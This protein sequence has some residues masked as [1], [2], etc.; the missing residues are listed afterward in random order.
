MEQINTKKKAIQMLCES[1]HMI[2][3]RDLDKYTDFSIH[4]D[5][6]DWWLRPGASSS[7]ATSF[8][9]QE[10][11]EI[12]DAEKKRHDSRPMFMNIHTGSVDSRDG[13]FYEVDGEKVNAVDREE[14]IQVYWNHTLDQ[15]VSVTK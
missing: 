9:R 5:G 1:T 3:V 11:L 4:K 7:P 10:L 13:W 15:Y 12:L 8:T 14:V 2:N 6:H